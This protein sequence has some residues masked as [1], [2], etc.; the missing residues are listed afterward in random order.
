ME[1]ATPLIQTSELVLWGET[2]REKLPALTIEIAGTG[3]TCLLGEDST[4]LAKYLRTMGG[5]DDY[6]SGEL[7]LFGQTF[8]KVSQHEWRRTRLN[9]GFVTRTAPL[10]SVLN[11]MENVIL[12]A[13]YHKIMARA[14]AEASA[15]V[16]LS[17]LH[18][19]ADL[20]LLPAYLTPL[21]RT[22]LAIARAA[23]MSPPVLLLEEPYHELE[24]N[25]HNTINAFLAD[26][27]KKQA[28]VVATR[29]L[30]FVKQQADK[31]IFAGGNKILYFDTWQ[32][33]CDSDNEDVIHY[34][35]QYQDNYAIW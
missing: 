12:P 24:V 5:V 16:I 7:K 23:I 18:C 27:A 31:I 1:T 4:I 10:L 14:E 29:N 25:E 28:L 19:T 20:S 13:L 3:T 2:D 17:G 11:G 21:E 8:A 30:H 6:R 15:K 9:I 35:K 22:Q 26:W 33:L 32:T 34:L